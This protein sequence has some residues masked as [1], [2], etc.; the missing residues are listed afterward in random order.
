MPLDLQAKLLR[1]LQEGEVMP[2]GDNRPVKIDIR[3]VSA[4]NRPLK[5]LIE[6][7]GFREDL[8]FR[9]N[10]L[11]LDLP[12]LR[13][14][15]EDIPLLLEFFMARHAGPE[16]SAHKSLDQKAKACLLAHQW[17]GNVRELENLVKYLWAVAP[18]PDITEEHLPPSYR[19]H[20][21]PRPPACRGRKSPACRKRR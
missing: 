10:V 16:L 13:E 14:R 9:L 11:P 8:F 12:S 2:I 19:A 3:V 6:E 18:G 20:S 1:V 15:K 7:G 17:P 21:A 5:E 4:T